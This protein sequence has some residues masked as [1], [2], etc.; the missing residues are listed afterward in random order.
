MTPK[1]RQEMVNH[2]TRELNRI[3]RLYRQH[4]PDFNGKVSL[5]GHSLG[6]L[7]AFDI[8]CHQPKHQEEKKDGNVGGGKEGGAKKKVA[9]M[10]L[11]DMMS[12][13][14]SADERRVKGL[15]GLDR[16]S[17]RYE[18]LEFGVDSLFVVGSPVGLFMLLKGDKLRAKL[19]DDI[20]GDGGED[21][22]LRPECAAVYNVF[23]PHDP[24][25]YRIEPIIRKEYADLKPVQ[26][27]YT[28]GGLKGTVLGIADLGNDLAARAGY[29]FES[30]WARTAEVVSTAGKVASIVSSFKPAA[31]T[32]APNDSTPNPAVAPPEPPNAAETEAAKKMEKDKEIGRLNPRGRIDYALQE[33]VLENPY[34]SA[35]GVHMSYWPDAD[36]AMFILGE[37]WRNEKVPEE[38]K[39]GE[40]GGEKEKEGKDGKGVMGEKSLSSSGGSA[41][42][43]E[44][45]K[46]STSG[47]GVLGSTPP[48]TGSGGFA[49]WFGLGG[50]AAAPTGGEKEKE[51]EK[52]MGKVVTKVEVVPAEVALEDMAGAGLTKQTSEVLSELDHLSYL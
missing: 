15:L 13:A 32:P 45:R 25:A 41:T 27:Q 22:V 52:E 29:V 18:A 11:S 35:L 16:P 14:I 40:K 36:V 24:V 12:G 28:K 38:E 39:A 6:S 31:P 44:K 47:E 46:P 23:H 19:V 20:A 33:G 2:V 42:G 17:I 49:S 1:Y 51:K 37:L 10:D 7:L 21:G 34:L 5:Y 8:L 26:L 48:R 4:N 3:V 43:L 50:V 30:V 9:E